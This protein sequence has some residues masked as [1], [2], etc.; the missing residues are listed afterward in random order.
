MEEAPPELLHFP[1]KL[2]PPLP[3]ASVTLPLVNPRR[4]SIIFG[5]KRETIEDSDTDI[6]IEIEIEIEAEAEIE[7]KIKMR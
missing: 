6:E 5:R 3:F 4:R 2:S 1:L 7:I